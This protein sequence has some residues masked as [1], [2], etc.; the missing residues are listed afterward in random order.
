MSALETKQEREKRKTRNKLK[1]GVARRIGNNRKGGRKRYNII[2]SIESKY[3]QRLDKL[4]SKS[5]TKKIDE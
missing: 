5:N 2:Q 1:R 4:Q 3:F